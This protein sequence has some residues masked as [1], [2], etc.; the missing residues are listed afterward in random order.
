MNKNFLVIGDLFLDIYS[1]Y[2]S[3]RNSPEV[4]AP[5][6]INKRIKYFL[7]GA[8]NVAANL[9]SLKQMVILLSFFKNDST[10][11][12]IKKI[13]SQKKIIFKF[14]EKKNFKNITKERILCNSMQIARIDSEKKNLAN[15]SINSKIS[16]FIK[17]NINLIKCVIISDYGKGFVNKKNIQIITDLCKKKNI[18]V[19][20]DPKSNNPSI[21]KNV[22]FLCPNYKEFLNFYPKLNFKKK[23][24]KI[25][26]QAKINYLL[27][28]KGKKGCSIVNK[29]FLSKNF[30]AKHVKEFDVSGAGDTF[31]A[32]FASA[33]YNSWDVDKSAD[34]ANRMSEDS[35]S[36]KFIATP[37]EK[38][39]KNHMRTVNKKKNFL[40]Q[41]SIWKKQGYKI[42]LTNGCFDLFHRGHAHLLDECKKYCDK[43]I[44]LLNS[45]YS[46]KAIKG[47][48]RPIENLKKR[49]F[50]ISSNINVDKCVIF[51]SRTPLSLIKKIKPNIIFKGSDYTKNNVVGFD[52]MK[53]IKGT[54]KIIKRYK[55]FST[56]NL[57]IKGLPIFK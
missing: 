29:R 10:G 6:L 32:S 9:R 37:E 12:K 21:Y 23:I 30:R 47:N 35:V 5:V 27:I 24:K 13:I 44:V 55:N 1:A 40:K 34:F 25:F 28:T 7:G 26:E 43:L 20:A 56:T 49:L 41:I 15:N 4:K 19:F 50:N 17:K 42:G 46:V 45:D 16:H 53:R 11:K 51:N 36:K 3:R 39:F 57:I 31:I 2:E 18:L 52:L 33:F 8:G 22:N 38:L 54:V 14:I 48:N